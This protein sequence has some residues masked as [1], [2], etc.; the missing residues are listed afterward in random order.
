MLL[1]IFLS[2]TTFTIHAMASIPSGVKADYYK[3]EEERNES[4]K[5]KKL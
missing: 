4:P 5:I 3:G 1:A 2:A